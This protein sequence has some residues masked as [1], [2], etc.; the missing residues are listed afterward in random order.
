MRGKIPRI[1]E[2]RRRVVTIKFIKNLY[3]RFPLFLAL[4]MA[5]SLP[6][7]GDAAFADGVDPAHAAIIAGLEDNATG[8]LHLLWE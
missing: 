6:P 4:V 1:I 8:I 7:G 2:I 3:F 5:F